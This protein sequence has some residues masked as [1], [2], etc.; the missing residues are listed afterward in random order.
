MKLT[1]SVNYEESYFKHPVLTA[2]RGEYTYEKIH[3][4][5]N[6]LKANAS[7]VPT[8]L[9]GGNH[10]YLGMILTPAEYRHISPTDP[11]TQIPNPGVLVPNP[12]GTAAQIASTENTHRL[13][14]I[15]IFRYPTSQ[16]NLNPTNHQVHR[17]QIS[18][19]PSQTHHRKNYNTRPDH[20]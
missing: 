3:H 13:K 12:A 1:S 2:I 16:T 10:G 4:L 6:E 15:Y 14:N 9:G 5:K 19:R 20:P 8:T 7:L 18:R 11:L 17:H